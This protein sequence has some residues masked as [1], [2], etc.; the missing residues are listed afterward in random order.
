MEDIVFRYRSVDQPA[1][2]LA[3]SAWITSGNVIAE[4]EIGPYSLAKCG[5]YCVAA[6]LHRDGERHYVRLCLQAGSKD[7]RA[8]N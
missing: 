3:A 5:N 6:F 4:R 7:R 1:P 2:L 8:K